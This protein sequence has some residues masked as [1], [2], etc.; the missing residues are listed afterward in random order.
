KIADGTVI[1]V[2]VTS[3]KMIHFAAGEDGWQTLVYKIPGTVA[4]G[5]YKVI[6]DEYA[7]TD[8]K[9]TV[10]LFVNSTAYTTAVECNQDDLDTENNKRVVTFTLYGAKEDGMLLMIGNYGNGSNMETYYRNPRVYLVDGEG[11]PEGENLVADFAEDNIV[12]AYNTSRANA[13]FNKWTALNWTADRVILEDVKNSL[14]DGIDYTPGD[15]NGDGEVDNK[16]LTRLFQFL[17]NWDVEVN[18]DALDVNG[19]GSVDNKDLT[20]LFQYLSNWDVEIF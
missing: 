3:T 15:I 14:F 7:A 8:V 5:T 19:D 13:E 18:E 17:S 10:K 16:D 6:I 2:K 20:R 4:A 11:N 9:S 12:F 1:P